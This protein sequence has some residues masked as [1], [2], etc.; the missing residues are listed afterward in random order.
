MNSKAAKVAA[1]ALLVVAVGLL[2]ALKF[3]RPAAKESS[4]SPRAPKEDSRSPRAREES[5]SRA[6]SSGKARTRREAFEGAKVNASE[7]DV[8]LDPDMDFYTDSGDGLTDAELADLKSGR[9]SGGDL[10]EAL[11]KLRGTAF[12]NLPVDVSTYLPS[13]NQEVRQAALAVLAG[14]GPMGLAKAWDAVRSGKDPEAK[15]IVMRMAAEKDGEGLA[16]LLKEGLE[17]DHPQLRYEAVELVEP[18]QGK[19][20]AV[21]REVLQASVKSPHS[22]VALAALEQLTEDPRKADLVILF[23]GLSHP[24]EEV[25][26]S[27]RGTI[28]FLIDHEFQ[29]A[30]EARAWWQENGKSFDDE[31]SPAE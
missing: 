23:D 17:S 24:D 9:L 7:V 20:E 14:S 2:I 22:D 19:N 13:E 28:D 30:E 11:A 18:L 10:A 27:A 26:S 3:P 1:L 29:T 5:G 31:L 6:A 15:L 16:A 8:E 21:R 25:S 4:G 12:D